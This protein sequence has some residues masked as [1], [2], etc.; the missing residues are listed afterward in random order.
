MKYST[1]KVLFWTEATHIWGVLKKKPLMD[2]D[3]SPIN[4]LIFLCLRVIMVP[5]MFG[6]QAAIYAIIHIAP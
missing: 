6:A 2:N 3:L 4:C 1:G 5:A